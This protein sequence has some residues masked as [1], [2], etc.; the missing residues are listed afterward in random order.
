M[1]VWRVINGGISMQCHAC[2]ASGEDVCRE[3]GIPVRELRGEP[4]MRYRRRRQLSEET[5]DGEKMY[6]M[7]CGREMKIDVWP[8]IFAGGWFAQARCMAEGG[9]RTCLK[10][11]IIQPMGCGLWMTRPVRAQGKEEAERLLRQTAR[12]SWRRAED[13]TVCA[14]GFDGRMY[15][16]VRG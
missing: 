16:N 2:G 12:R 4:M 13:K 1:H 5:D 3:L 7:A 6:C 15:P 11:E 8:D 9:Q 14:D 10:D